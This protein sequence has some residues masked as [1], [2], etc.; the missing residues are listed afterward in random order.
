MSADNQRVFLV[1]GANNGI[2]FE[3]V[4]KLATKQPNDIILLGCRDQK[5]GDDA[6]VQLG[7]PSNV[8][9]LLVETSS[10]E[11]IK[12]AKEEI[13]K[14]YGGK[15]DVLINNAGISLLGLDSKTLKT[16]LDTNYYGVKNMNE[17]FFPLI[18]DNGRVVNVSSGAA[19]QVMGF[20]PQELKDKLLSANITEEQ[21]N[22][23]LAT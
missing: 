8:K 20:C 5:R 11:S 14:K 22:E 23:V 12:H 3:V 7:S 4:K 2:G 16:L 10:P 17:T 21:L 1:T 18:R 19:S 15:L 13:Q 9:T 6:L